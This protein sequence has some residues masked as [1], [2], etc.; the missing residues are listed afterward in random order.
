MKFA[1]V[2]TTDKSMNDKFIGEKKDDGTWDFRDPFA[3][4]FYNGF[5]K[6]GSELHTIDMY[7]DY[8]D[9]DFILFE[10]PR[11]DW[12]RRLINAGQATKMIYYN[13]EPATV[14]KENTEKGYERMETIF[15]YIMT[16][17][18]HKVDNTTY[19]L[20]NTPYHFVIDRGSVPYEDKKLLTAISGNRK[21]KGVNP[22]AELYSE[23][24]KIYKFFERNYPEEFDLYGRGWNKESH[25]C[26]KGTV[27]NKLVTYHGYRFAI[28]LENTKGDIDYVSEKI[29]DCLC[30]GIVPIYGGAPNISEIIPPRCFI[31]YFSFDSE[32][33]LAQYIV[34]MPQEK[35]EEYVNNGISFIDNLDRNY[36]TGE[37]FVEQIIEVTKHKK[38][39]RISRN[40]FVYVNFKGILY[41]MNSL[42]IEL[43]NLFRK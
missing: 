31:D 16:F 35:Y 24:E 11:W 12:I 33:E 17:V 19:F 25:P 9:I 23:R 30:A 6:S 26:Y 32:E 5:V 8:D 18:K 14:L 37:K 34:N 20:K 28:C 38:S 22:E 42:K 40:A 21:P 4:E 27:D 29:Y 41:S 1:L 3:E 15:P 13:S 39:F 2:P 43:L 36:Y 10:W 7:E